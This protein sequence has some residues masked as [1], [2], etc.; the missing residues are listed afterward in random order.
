MILVRNIQMEKE[1]VNSFFSGI[2]FT[3]NYIIYYNNYRSF[4]NTVMH[5]VRPIYD[6][7]YRPT[8]L[9]SFVSSLCG[10]QIR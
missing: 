6:I 2:V 7:R 10:Q 9:L 3:Q 5:L 4:L 8:M 1:N